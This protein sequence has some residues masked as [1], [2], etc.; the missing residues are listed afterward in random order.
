MQAL[1]A[2]A[3]LLSFAPHGN[4]IEFRLDHGAAEL[5]W[6]SPSTFRFRRTLDG[7][8]PALTTVTHPSIAVRIE[9]APDRVRLRSEFLDISILKHGALVEVRR[10]DGAPLVSDISEPHSS[11]A[12]VTWERKAPAD[13]RYYG[14]GPRSDKSFDARGKAVAAE[15]PFLVTTA[16]YGEYHPGAGTFRFDFTAGDRYSIRAPSVDYYFHFGP[17]IKQIFEEH[18]ELPVTAQRWLAATDR[19][20]SWETLRIAL[21]RIV[22]GAMSAMT[23]PSLPLAPYTG[24]PAELQ[25]RARQLGSLVD[26]VSPGVLGLSGLRKQLETFFATYAAEANEKGFPVWHPLPFQFPED[27]ECNFHTDE[28]MLGDEMLIAP[29]LQ[30]GGK[31]SVYLPRGNWTN[32]ETNQLT[33]GKQTIEVETSSLPV[34]ARNGT[35]VPL[36]AKGGMALH[37]FPSLGAEFFLLETD[38]DAWTQVHAAPAAD[39]MRL[40]IEAKKARDY[41]WVV[42]HVEKPADVS[43]EGHKY[44]EARSDSAMT[45]RSWFYDAGQKNLHV[46]VHVAAGEDCIINLTF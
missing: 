35:I 20:G 46:R 12:G 2:V 23:A 25:S 5:V 19:F 14:L 21:L 18:K 8:L 15:V 43:F 27:A 41:Q 3:T 13:V 42:H 36:D 6:S 9:D 33:P 1:A 32:L 44:T 34:F 22:H 40:E 37:Y 39:I 10:V 45:D 11:G 4:Q 30:P 38:P 28:F 7:A 31:R 26:D 24:A 17:T 29:I 16:G